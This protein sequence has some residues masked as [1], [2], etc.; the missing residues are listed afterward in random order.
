MAFW[1]EWTWQ[2]VNT[3][4]HVLS[5]D[6]LSIHRELP[7][8]LPLHQR[9]CSTTLYLVCLSK[10]ASILSSIFCY[11]SSYTQGHGGRSVNERLNI[12]FQIENKNTTKKPTSLPFP[13]ICISINKTLIIQGHINKYYF[14]IYIIIHPVHPSSRA[15]KLVNVRVETRFFSSYFGW[16]A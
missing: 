6:N 14:C 4:S 12:T 16:R 5:C 1:H 7:H 10:N 11:R 8:G 15:C 13:K 9:L 2:F 3:L